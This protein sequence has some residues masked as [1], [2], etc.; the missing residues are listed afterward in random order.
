M[1]DEQLKNMINLYQAEQREW[2]VIWFYR[3]VEEIK[4]KVIVEIGI[5]EGGNLKI[6]STHLD[7]DGLAVGIDPRKEIP[8]KMNDSTC[9]VVHICG[10]SHSLSTLNQLKEVLKERPIDVLF[11]DGD[12]STA[13]ML[14]DYADYSPLVRKGGLIAVHDIYYLEEV[15]QAWKQVPGNHKYESP[16]NQS[17]IGIGYIKK[18]E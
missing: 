10:D 6:L 12:H 8:W 11:I 17:S 13:G 7:K 5:K 16:W 4:P 1:N 9:E 15:K 14:A 3:A 2:E 18:G